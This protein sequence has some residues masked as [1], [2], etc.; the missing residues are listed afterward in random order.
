[1]THSSVAS[2]FDIIMTY[3]IMKAIIVSCKKKPVSVSRLFEPYI[4]ESG[5]WLCCFRKYMSLPI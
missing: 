2:D 4:K 3:G 1:M 5:E